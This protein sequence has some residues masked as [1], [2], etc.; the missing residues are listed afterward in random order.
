MGLIKI[1]FWRSYFSGPFLENVNGGILLSSVY[2]CFYDVCVTFSA[3][4]MKL[5]LPSWWW[6]KLF[7]SAGLFNNYK[8]LYGTA[9]E[10]LLHKAVSDDLKANVQAIII[11][12]N[13]NLEWS[14]VMRLRDRILKLIDL[15]TRYPAIFEKLLIPILSAVE[16]SVFTAK[17]LPELCYKL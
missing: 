1:L 10:G 7:L 8:T 17:K 3:A 11:D 14:P 5:K 12:K 4:I 6:C 16:K 15:I 2:Q 13:I 9:F